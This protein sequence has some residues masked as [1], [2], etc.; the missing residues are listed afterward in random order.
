VLS[1]GEE[2]KGRNRVHGE[3]KRAAAVMIVPEGRERLKHNMQYSPNRDFMFN[4][5]DKVAG[6]KYAMELSEMPVPTT[7]IFQ[8]DA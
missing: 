7:N 4:G 8:H 1:T 2:S 5:Q 6:V 3:A